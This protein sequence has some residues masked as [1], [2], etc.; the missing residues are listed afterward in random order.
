MKNPNQKH[1]QPMFD[2]IASENK[3]AAEKREAAKSGE[4]AELREEIALLKA[5][6]KK[7]KK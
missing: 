7:L 4:V 3:A 2:K 6:I 5:E 1:F